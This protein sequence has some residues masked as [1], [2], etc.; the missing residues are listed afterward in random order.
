MQI[1]DG[2][3]TATSAATAGDYIAA[4]QD[5]RRLPLFLTGMIQRCQ[6]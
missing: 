6:P 3:Q 2:S 5:A 4:L 1:K